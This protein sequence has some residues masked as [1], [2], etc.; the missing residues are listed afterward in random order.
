M[1]AA[2]RDDAAC[3]VRH[4]GGMTRSHAETL[5]REAVHELAEEP[6]PMNVRRYLAA[7]QILERAAQAEPTARAKGKDQPPGALALERS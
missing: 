4:R 3:A 2:R 1:L 6:N 5:F 7:S